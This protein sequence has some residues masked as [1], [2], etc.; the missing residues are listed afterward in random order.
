MPLYRSP[1][2]RTAMS[3]TERPER[4]EETNAHLEELEDGCGCAEVWEHLSA[5]RGA[6]RED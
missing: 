1:P 2:Y 6:Q 5:E 4:S 3:E